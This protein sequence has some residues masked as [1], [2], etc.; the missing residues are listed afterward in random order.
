MPAASSM[1]GYVGVGATHGRTWRLRHAGPQQ[2]HPSTRPRFEL[3]ARGVLSGNNGLINA[4][5][6]VIVAGTIS[7]GNSPRPLSIDCNL[8]TLAGSRLILDVLGNGA[9]FDIDHLRIGNNS[10]FDLQQPADR[11]QLPRQHRSRMPSSRRAASTSTTS[12]NRSTSPTGAVSG[13]STVFAAGETGPTSSTRANSPRCRAST[14]SATSSCRPTAR[15]RRRRAGPGAVD[16]GDAA[17]RAAR[18]DHVRASVGAP[19][20]GLITRAACCCDGSSLS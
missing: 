9:G 14:T 12:C 19:R 2:Q 13:L 15:Q 4:S 7:P 18:L 8:I 16:L 20:S 1:P 3:G 17:V 6:N 10:T 5:G 11:P